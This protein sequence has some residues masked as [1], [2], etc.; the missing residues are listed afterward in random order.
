MEIRQ[1]EQELQSGLNEFFKYEICYINN[2]SSP[3]L[4]ILDYS[5]KN[6]DPPAS[7][8][9]SLEGYENNGFPSKCWMTHTE[10][11]PFNNEGNP[12]KRNDGYKKFS[13]QEKEFHPFSVNLSDYTPKNVASIKLVIDRLYRHIKF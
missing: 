12:P 8:A 4:I 11:L 10:I 13:H 9:L 3:V 1:I 5:P 2:E 7:F 6:N